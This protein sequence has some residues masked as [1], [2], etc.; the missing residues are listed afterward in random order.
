MSICVNLVTV[1]RVSAISETVTGFFQTLYI[2][3]FAASQCIHWPTSHAI[4]IFGFFLRTSTI[5]D[6][7]FSRCQLKKTLIRA[8]HQLPIYSTLGP[9]HQT[10]QCQKLSFLLFALLLL[11]LK[12][13]VIS[14]TSSITIVRLTLASG[15]LSPHTKKF[16]WYLIRRTQVGHGYL[17]T[18]KISMALVNFATKNI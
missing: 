18:L 1:L 5:L 6:H 8:S 12:V 16:T 14:T 7:Q 10:I 15:P 13:G 11:S 4:I 3:P 9:N 2:A 17:A